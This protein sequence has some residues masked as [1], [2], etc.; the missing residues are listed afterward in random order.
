MNSTDDVK[1]SLRLFKLFFFL[2]LYIHCTGCLL[3]YV[4][5]LDKIWNP[6]Q[7]TYNEIEYSLY[8]ADIST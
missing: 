1:L 8:D 2:V 4:A 3:F 6:A 5:K 7:F